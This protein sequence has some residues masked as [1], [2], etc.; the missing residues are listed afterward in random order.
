MVGAPPQGVAGVFHKRV[1]LSSPYPCPTPTVVRRESAR[2]LQLSPISELV[3]VRRLSPAGGQ[4]VMRWRRFL[5]TVTACVCVTIALTSLLQKASCE[6]A[7]LQQ[8]QQTRGQSPVSSSVEVCGVL[9]TR[10]SLA[11]WSRLAFNSDRFF[12]QGWHSGPRPRSGPGP[13]PAVPGTGPA[14]LRQCTVTPVCL[15][16][17][18][19]KPAAVPEW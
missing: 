4:L 19:L 18:S 11:A 15:H 2:F 1:L 12:T 14:V 8:R 5:S 17:N 13:L 6:I 7:T 10:H 16:H 3:S 9:V